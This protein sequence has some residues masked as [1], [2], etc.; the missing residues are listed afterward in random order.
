M[1]LSIASSSPQQV[2]ITS[3]EN[4]KTR[5]RLEMGSIRKDECGFC[6]RVFE[7]YSAGLPRPPV[8]T[9]RQKGKSV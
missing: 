1:R 5:M 3:E 6:V 7:R 4:K 9:T 8:S 2:N